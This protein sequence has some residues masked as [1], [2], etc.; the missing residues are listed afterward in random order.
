[1]CGI[2]TQLND[3]D[4]RA[5]YIAGNISFGPNAFDGYVDEE[6]I[7]AYAI[8]FVKGCGEPIGHPMTDG[9]DHPVAIVPKRSGVTD[10]CCR[11]DAYRAEV[12]EKVPAGSDRLVIVPLTSAGPLLVGELTEIISDL[13]VNNTVD[14]GQT[15]GGM[16]SKQF[17]W[18][19]ATVTFV[20]VASLLTSRAG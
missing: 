6:P 10:T 2:S 14:V 4:P 18:S 16:G 5:G 12:I 20:T 8:Y 3:T 19:L 17:S 13:V 1:M 11:H 7:S 9:D 15:S